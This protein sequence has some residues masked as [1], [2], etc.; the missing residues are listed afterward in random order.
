MLIAGNDEDAKATVATLVEDF[1]WPA[2]VDAGGIEASRELEEL[3]I[4]WVRVGG[5]RGAWDHGFKLLV[6]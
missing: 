2:P 3:A 4:L 5:M 1:G 6:G